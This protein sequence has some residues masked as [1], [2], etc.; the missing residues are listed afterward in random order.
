L[1]GLHLE[2]RSHRSARQENLRR[3]L[4]HKTSSEAMFRGLC[5]P[6]AYSSSRLRTA[7]ISL[8]AAGELKH[9]L[10]PG[11]GWK[12]LSERLVPLNISIMFASGTKSSVLFE[13]IAARVSDS[14][15]PSGVFGVI[16]TPL[17]NITLGQRQVIRIPAPYSTLQHSLRVVL[18]SRN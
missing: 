8:T 16:V 2:R 12:Q 9:E 6:E 13:T 17:V 7:G 15:V 4:L 5:S 10:V 3:S 11:P 14:M 18:I 1:I